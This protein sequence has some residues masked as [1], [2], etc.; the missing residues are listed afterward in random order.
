MRLGQNVLNP[1][2]EFRTNSEEIKF[3][4][5][6]ASPLQVPGAKG[7]EDEQSLLYGTEKNA[8]ESWHGSR[9]STP[10]FL[11]LG[12]RGGFLSASAGIS[13]MKRKGSVPDLR[14]GVYQR[15][16]DEEDEDEAVRQSDEEIGTRDS[17]Q[18]LKREGITDTDSRVTS[19]PLLGL[20]YGA[21]SSTCNVPS[22]VGYACIIFSH[23]GFDKGGLMPLLIKLVFFSA[24]IHQLIMVL[25]STLRFAVGQVQDAG[26]IFLSAMASSLVEKIDGSAASSS[27]AS[28]RAVSTV[29]AC[30][31]I[32]TALVGI[33]LILTGYFRLAKLV[34]YLP[35]P[36]V[37]GY[38]SYIGMYCVEA[39]LSLMTGGVQVEGF[40]LTFPEGMTWSRA[41]IL[42]APGAAGAI[43]LVTLQSTVRHYAVLP[44]CILSM[45]AVFYAAVYASGHTL[46]EAQNFG[47]LDK[48]TPMV[49]FWDAFRLFKLDKVDW[50]LLPTQ[51]PSWIGLFFVVT[52]GSTLDVAAIEMSLGR[53][54]DYNKELT[55]IGLSNAISGV[56]GGFTGAHLTCSFCF[57]HLRSECPGV[58]RVSLTD[59][60]MS[61]NR[62][63]SLWPNDSHHEVRCSHAHN[64]ALRR[65]HRAGCFP[66][67]LLGAP[68]HSSLPFW[69]CALLYRVGHNA[70]LAVQF[71][72]ANRTH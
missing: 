2:P 61:S 1:L 48:P 4:S 18:A 12:T 54:L 45:P 36:V 47:F 34:Q 59:P 22:M 28:E 3:W 16:E 9:T 49:Q 21:I 52:F 56:T 58:S 70:G 31:A 69:G 19:D 57:S 6:A 38:L 8:Q 41:L 46:T 30:T 26:L 51:I 11:S 67:S 23:A 13:S 68:V 72:P 43:L 17:S 50:G 64:G 35:L 39:S 25:R 66:R 24:L 14:R 29:L 5:M 71:F 55:T 37:A 7:R 42:A 10:S 65:R 40:R 33:F 32:S 44:A 60:S 63:L 15:E 20:L 62:E 27:G 53:K